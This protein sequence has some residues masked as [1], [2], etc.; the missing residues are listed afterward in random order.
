MSV[1]P[2]IGTGSQVSTDPGPTNPSSGGSIT[3]GGAL[4]GAGSPT[5]GSSTIILPTGNPGG[6]SISQPGPSD[7]GTSN[8]GTSSNNG[9]A[10]GSGV[11][12]VEIIYVDP[13]TDQLNNT[14][15]TPDTNHSPN[16][17]AWCDGDDVWGHGID[18]GHWNSHSHGHGNFDHG[19]R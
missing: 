14:G 13:V 10:G 18:S 3:E 5:D 8:S 16:G 17:G 6:T 1:Y 19:I 11:T 4:V 9:A 2:V 7:G 15:S 12:I